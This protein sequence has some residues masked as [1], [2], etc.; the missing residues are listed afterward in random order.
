MLFDYFNYHHF[1]RAKGVIAMKILFIYNGAEHLGLEY[2]SSF[3]KS[4]GHETDLLFDPQVFSPEQFVFNNRAMDR[5]FSLDKKIIEKAVFMK[6]DIIAFSAFTSNYRWC[7][8][9]AE[10][11]KKRSSIT[12]VFGGV[13]TTAATDRVLENDFIDYAVIGEGEYAM[14]DLI[15]C[16]ENNTSRSE[17]LNIPNLCMKHEGQIVINA[18][19]PYID[20]LDSLPFPDKQ[21]F[22]D[23]VPMFE[24]TYLA[25]SSRGC[26]YNCTY[27]SNTMYHKIYCNENIHI[28]KRT[29][30]NVIEEFKKVKERGKTK[31]ILFNDEVFVS[32]M[33]WLEEF[34][35]RYPSEVGIPYFCS[36][37]PGTVKKKTAELLK[38]SGCWCTAM[39]VQSGSERIRKEIFHRQGTNEQIIEA[40]LNIKEAGILVNVDNI[41]GAPTEDEGDLE[42]CLKLYLA[43]RPSRIQTFWLTYFPGTEII[44]LALKEKYI[45]AENVKEIEE[46]YVGNS[47]V[48]GSM[49]KCKIRFYEKYSILFHTLTIFTSDRVYNN[50]SRILL[51]L[52]L[53]R[54]VEK[55]LMLMEAFKNRDFRLFNY[56]RYIWTKKI[57]P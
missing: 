22:Y 9:I 3:L 25:L 47:N 18:P 55:F 12:I 40:V 32:S 48:V 2:L 52:P 21:L 14:L 29:V 42:E 53:K 46:G 31:L 35:E 7:L 4:R 56:I 34:S 28:R 24:E 30:E 43:I 23:K 57:V 6:P 36:L 41:F 5:F 37:H 54:Q 13:H 27:C 8:K 51:L 1:L 16:I 33:K 45:T 11:I 10:G 49:P 20:E 38:K 19:R 26:P 39:G 44:S 15:D 50:I 17:M